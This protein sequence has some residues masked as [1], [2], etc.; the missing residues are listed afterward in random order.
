MENIAFTKKILKNSEDVGWKIYP[1]TDLR[2]WTT[3]VCHMWQQVIDRFHFS[4]SGLTGITIIQS[5]SMLPSIGFM[6][7]CKSNA[8]ITLCATRWC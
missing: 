7:Q 6:A 3:G 2:F 1:N 4:N 5:S 8:A